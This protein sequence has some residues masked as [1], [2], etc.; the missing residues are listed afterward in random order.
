MTPKYV[1]ILIPGPSDYVMRQ[2]GIKS[3]GG[4]KVANEMTLR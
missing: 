2:G 4:I 3:A 1:Q